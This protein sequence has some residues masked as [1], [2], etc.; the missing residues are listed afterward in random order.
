LL[1]QE[2]CIVYVDGHTGLVHGSETQHPE[3]LVKK[4]G[5]DAALER[6]GR[7]CLTLTHR[8]SD[9]DAFAR[10]E[11]NDLVLMRNE[12]SRRQFDTGILDREFRIKKQCGVILV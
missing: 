9:R 11:R 6:S 12:R 8:K 1:D 3:S 4:T 2:N 5:Q 7:I 10:L